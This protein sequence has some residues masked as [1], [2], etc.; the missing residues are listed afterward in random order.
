MLKLAEMFLVK[1]PTQHK[2]QDSELMGLHLYLQRK[3]GKHAEA[4]AS[5]EA[6]AKEIGCD[7]SAAGPQM[8]EG[9]DRAAPV[10]ENPEDGPDENSVRGMMLCGVTRGTISA[11]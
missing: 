8:R 2:V 4:L 3:Q 10:R 1:A 9:D 6:Y 11:F 5:L 7:V